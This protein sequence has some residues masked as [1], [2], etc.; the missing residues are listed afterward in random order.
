M[1]KELDKRK[2][3]HRERTKKASGVTFYWY[4]FSG[5]NLWNIGIMLWNVLEF[6]VPNIVQTLPC[7]Y[8]HNC[9][10]SLF[11]IA[12]NCQFTPFDF[13][14]IYLNI[15]L[16]NP[17]LFN[18]SRDGCIR[19]CDVRTLGYNWPVMC[20]KQGKMASITCIR[21]LRNENHLLSSGL[22]G[23]VRSWSMF[24]GYWESFVYAHIYCRLLTEEVFL[25]LNHY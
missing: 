4:Y 24:N 6:L 14:Q 22:D 15:I 9:L 13:I 7:W 21:A 25:W 18:G 23:S 11:L 2:W 19:T 16:Q 12:C 3:H 5:W 1:K 8:F 17:V 10:T 20:L